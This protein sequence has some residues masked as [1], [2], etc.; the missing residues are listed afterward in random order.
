VGDRVNVSGLD[1]VWVAEIRLFTCSFDTQ[2]HQRVILK[3]TAVA[4]A[5]IANKNLYTRRRG[6]INLRTAYD[7]D[8]DTTRAVLTEI[9]NALPYN[10]DN[11]AHAV[12]LVGLGASSVDRQ[13]RI[14]CDT[15]DYWN[16]WEATVRG[17]KLSL[18]SANIGIPYDALDV[19]VTALPGQ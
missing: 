8:I 17:A 9:V 10:V 11:H 7:A 18:E 3:N 14:W 6:H 12:F 1:G 5:P 15:Q 13:L 4:S 16:C 19:N 2:N